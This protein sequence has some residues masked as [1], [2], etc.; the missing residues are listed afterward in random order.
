LDDIGPIPH[1]HVEMIAHHGKAKD[2]DPEMS[3]KE[4]DAI[5]HP[6]P[7]MLVVLSRDRIAATQERASY[8]TIDA[9]I[10]SDFG[11]IDQKPAADPRHGVAPGRMG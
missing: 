7:A 2:V 4:L 8:A 1:D 6:L 3:R 9:V 11:G 10:D 5:L